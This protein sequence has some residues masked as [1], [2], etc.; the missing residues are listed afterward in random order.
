MQATVT[1]SRVARTGF[2][3]GCLF[4]FVALL[5][6]KRFKRQG[7]NITG[8]LGEPLKS[9]H[10]M[11]TEKNAMHGHFSHGNKSVVE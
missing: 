5:A 7:R 10:H 4:G 9:H 11:G 6:N 8:D 2:L 1:A 3:F